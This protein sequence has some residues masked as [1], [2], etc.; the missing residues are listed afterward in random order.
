M[1]IV[2]ASLLLLL[3]AVSIFFI[4]SLTFIDQNLRNILYIFPAIF[5]FIF[6][7]KAISI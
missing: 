2:E 1:R 3:V 5:L 4:S 7:Y 6:L